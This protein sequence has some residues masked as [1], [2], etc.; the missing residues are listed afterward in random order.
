MV[1]WLK[2]NITYPE[3]SVGDERVLSTEVN[4]KP[5]PSVMRA[6]LFVYS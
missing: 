2:W 3:C 5:C 1:I 4:G 6:S